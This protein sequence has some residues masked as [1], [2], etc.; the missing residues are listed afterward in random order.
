M[1]T[2]TPETPVELPICLCGCGKP[3]KYSKSMFLQG[4]DQRLVSKLAFELVEAELSDQTKKTLQFTSKWNEGVDIQDRIS[5]VT[6][7]VEARFSTGLAAKVH[8]AAMRRWE[9][10]AA[11]MEKARN[12]P[13]VGDTVPVKIGR[14]RYEAKVLQVSKDG[15]VTEVEYEARNDGGTK[16]AD[17]GFQVL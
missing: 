6:K 7:Q 1:T 11:R 5:L 15:K 8:R 4:H 12:A 14:W 9:T 13:K 17:K 2:T 10:Y 16:T 3:V